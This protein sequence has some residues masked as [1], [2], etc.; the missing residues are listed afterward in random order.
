MLI[1]FGD[2]DKSNFYFSD[3]RLTYGCFNIIR[4]TYVIQY[5]LIDYLLH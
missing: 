2:T 4:I 5:L 1:L 3:S